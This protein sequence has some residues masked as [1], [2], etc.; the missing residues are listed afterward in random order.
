VAFRVLAADYFPAR[1]NIR[2]FRALH[3]SEFTALFTQVVRLA[4]EMG[5]VKLATCFKA[6]TRSTVE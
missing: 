6:L 1:R 4:R 2:D 5:R 3:L